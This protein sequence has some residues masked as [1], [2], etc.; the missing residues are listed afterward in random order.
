MAACALAAKKGVGRSLIIYARPRFKYRPIQPPRDPP[1]GPAEA[2]SV[3]FEGLVTKRHRQCFCRPFSDGYPAP[4]SRQTRRRLTGLR[5]RSK[6]ERTENL[7]ELGQFGQIRGVAIHAENHSVT[8]NCI[9]LDRPVRPQALQLFEGG[10]ALKMSHFTGALIECVNERR[11][12]CNQFWRPG[13][14]SPPASV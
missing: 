7:L 14:A 1:H 12:P 10:C 3:C 2:T 9:A 6:K 4:R 13:T 5:R 11:A 8:H